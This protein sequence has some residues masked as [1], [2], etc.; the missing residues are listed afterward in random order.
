METGQIV[1]GAHLP[2]VYLCDDPLPEK[3]IKDGFICYISVLDKQL[4]TALKCDSSV[5]VADFASKFVGKMSDRNMLKVKKEDYI[6][7]AK[8]ARDYLYGSH[9]MVN[10]EHIHKC[11][12]KNIPVELVLTDRDHVL[13]EVD[14]NDHN[15]CF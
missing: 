11:I 15:V 14:P 4:K 2:A 5:T 10:F 12:K 9:K 7:K 6:F 1:N 8:G 3:I 13:T